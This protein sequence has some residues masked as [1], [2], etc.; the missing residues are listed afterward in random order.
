MGYSRFRHKK[1]RVPLTLCA[2]CLN[3]LPPSVLLAE[4]LSGRGFDLVNVN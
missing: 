1:F 4:R 3:Q 2:E